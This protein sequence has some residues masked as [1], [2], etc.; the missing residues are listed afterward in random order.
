MH[1]TFLSRHT[2]QSLLTAAFLGASA[3]TAGAQGVASS[4]PKAA[5]PIVP[6]TEFVISATRTPQDLRHLPAAVTGRERF[7]IAARHACC[8]GVPPTPVTG[9]TRICIVSVC[10]LAFCLKI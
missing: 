9:H 1:T 3:L 4:A 8:E 5:D 7:L 2:T 10:G 6:L